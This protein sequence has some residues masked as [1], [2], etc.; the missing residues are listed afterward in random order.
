VEVGLPL[1]SLSREVLARWPALQCVNLFANSWSGE[2]AFSDTMDYP[3]LVGKVENATGWQCDEF[4]LCW[5][6][7][8]CEA[9]Q[10]TISPNCYHLETTKEFDLCAWARGQLAPVCEGYKP[11]RYDQPA[12]RFCS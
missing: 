12:C 11:E 1:A 10:S 9:A 6:G 2:A 5:K 8:R 3:E 4:L 7:D